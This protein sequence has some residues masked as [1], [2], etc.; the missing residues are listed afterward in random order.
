MFALLGALCF[1]FPKGGIE[2]TLR[3]PTLQEVFSNDTTNVDLEKNLQD[4][5]NTF[6]ATLDTLPEMF[7]NAD[8]LACIDTLHFYEAFDTTSV[9]RIYFPDNNP[10][11]MDGLFA[12]LEERTKKKGMLHILH[13]G[14]SQIEL[15]RISG[16]VRQALQ[17][18]FGGNGVGLLPIV[19]L[20]Q[21]TAVGQ[22]VSDSLPRYVASGTMRQ[23]VAHNRYGVMAQMA[24]L[25]GSVTLS[26]STRDWKQ[27]YEGTK[28][29]NRVRLFLGN[30]KENF[31]A[32]LSANGIDSTQ[33][34]EEEKFGMTELSWSLRSYVSNCSL[35]LKGN[36]ELYCVSLESTS[37][38]VVDNIPLRGSAGTFFTGISSSL[39]R[40]TMTALNVPLIIL[41]YGGNAVPAITS[42][43]A[44]QNYKK[45]F[46]RQIKYLKN[47]YPK[48]FILVIGP[49]DMSTKIDG[50]LQTW[51]YVE[52]VIQSMKEIALEN[53]AAFWNMFDVMGGR[54]SMIQW[55]SHKPAWAAPDY[56]HFS[57]Q[58]A[59]RIAEVFTQSFMH[60]YE[61]YKFL[62]RNS[63]WFE[64]EEDVA[65]EESDVEIEQDSLEVKN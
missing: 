63:I 45:D 22:T 46:G 11:V 42:Q 2:L 37:G 8:S 1:V 10:R 61:Y 54:N 21:T 9:A 60:Y 53:G 38:V 62:Q 57:P 14:D 3:F 4:I 5:E 6:V 29:F 20:I 30:N 31:K 12:T 36:A 13:Y 59:K 17:D 64:K 48:A 41:E 27:V 40:E 65:E 50:E 34:I 33:V 44:V 32:T 51:P 23:K 47:L 58:G 26:Y 56:I 18:T 28:K 24:E 55:V 39:L 16:Y 43:E 19:P 52:E 15:D 49:A 25:N 35:Q 7:E